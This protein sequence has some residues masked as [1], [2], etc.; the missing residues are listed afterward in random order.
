MFFM[1]VFN[2]DIFGKLKL[3]FILSRPAFHSVGVF[4]FLLGS[5]LAYKLNSNFRWDVFTL[6]VI[7]V[8]LIMLSTYH[9]G[10]Y[11]DFDGDIISNKTHKNRFAGGS[12]VLITKN[13]SKPIPLFT[14][15]ISIILAFIIGLIIQFKLKTGPYA[16]IFGI[17]GGFFGFFYSTKPLR[18]VEKGIGEIL[19]GFCYG[20]LPVASAYY[21]QTGE[22]S[23]EVH[24]TSIPIALTIFNVILLN[25]FPDYEADKQISK[26][27]LLQRIGKVNAKWLYI[28]ASIISSIFVFI[29]PYF[30]IPIKIIYFYIPIFLI[31][32]FINIMMFKK[33][34]ED[35]ILLEKLCGLNI[36]VNLGTT[37]AYILS[38]L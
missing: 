21:I 35:P 36:F 26:R 34:Y 15:I 20:W 27:N 32:T 7:A 13:I 16:L 24:I 23:K 30:G 12:R 6:G 5:I 4:P 31:S 2:Y 37:A 3:W 14:G 9:M 22:I 28:F 25:E 18:F 11:F 38:Y 8:I 29:S 1:Q 17:V 19:I 10:E 33:K